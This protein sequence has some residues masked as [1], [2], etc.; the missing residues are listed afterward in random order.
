MRI[1]LMGPPGVGKGTQARALAAAWGALHVSTGDILRQAVHDGTALGKKVR[2]YV[3]GGRLV[4]DELIGDLIGERLRRQDAEAGFILDGFPRTVEQVG[5][6]DRVLE[7]A[8]IGLDA[9]VLLVAPEEEIV[10]R[11]TGR[12]TCPGCGQVFHL[13]SRPPRAAGVCDACGSALV[14]RKD[15]SEEVI[16]ER[17]RV[18]ASQTLPVA[19]AYRER[20]R[21]LEVDGSG[22]P[23]A[24]TSRV[25][26]ALGKA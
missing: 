2:P 13:E 12:R 23:S 1:V 21:L 14:Q 25:Q 18:Y 5:L 15:D 7:G 17:L 11:L 9:A 10:R 4:P 6:L 24:V 22:E 8:G 3:D 20:G 19:Q 16:R 26:E